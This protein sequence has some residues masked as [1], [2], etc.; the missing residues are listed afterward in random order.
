MSDSAA[1]WTVACQIPLSV[2]FSRQEYRSE[3]PFATPGDLSNTG[4]KPAS[5]ASPVLAAGF[6]TTSST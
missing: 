2:E 1:P 5:L 6:F 4:I 3:L